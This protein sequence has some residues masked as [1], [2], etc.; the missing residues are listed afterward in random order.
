[1]LQWRKQPE[2]FVVI[3][4]GH[5]KH[6]ACNARLSGSKSILSSLNCVTSHSYFLLLQEDGQGISCVKYCF[7]EGPCL[8][9]DCSFSSAAQANLSFPGT[10]SRLTGVDNELR[11]AFNI[12][13]NRE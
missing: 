1:M 2:E 3:S 11:I 7:C 12:T 6:T 8:D 13:A 4:Q 9:P 10:Q 5:S